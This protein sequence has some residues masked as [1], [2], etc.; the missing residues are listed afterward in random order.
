MERFY[1]PQD[2]RSRIDYAV[3]EHIARFR[4]LPD[5]FQD[6]VVSL[7]YCVLIEYNNNILDSALN[8]YGSNSFEVQDARRKAEEAD[9]KAE[10][11]DRKI[12]ALSNTVLQLQGTIERLFSQVHGASYLQEGRIQDVAVNAIRT[13]E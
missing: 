5:N 10:E 3:R 9:R 8:E 11:V 7:I 12:E 6:K 2:L 1:Q 13:G 4:S